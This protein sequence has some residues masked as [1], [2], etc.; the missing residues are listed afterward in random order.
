MLIAL[1]FVELVFLLTVFV[2]P[3]S[4]GPIEVNVARAAAG[5][6]TGTGTP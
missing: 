5:A 6:A 2:A 4:V 1:A 3:G